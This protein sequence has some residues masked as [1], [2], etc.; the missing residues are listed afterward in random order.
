ADA[1]GSRFRLP[2]SRLAQRVAHREAPPVPSEWRGR[3]RARLAIC[4]GFF[5]LWTAGIEAR[6]VYLQVV[7]HA[8]MMARANR[9]QLRT[10]KLP[11]KR[12][13]IVDRAGHVLAYSVDADTIAADP[14]EID[15]PGAVATRV[16]AALEHCNAQQ[17]DVMAERLSGKGQ[18]T[19]LA[20]QVSPDD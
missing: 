17:R 20:R 6:L 16:C 18:F 3:L 1:H 7:E 12:G 10:V 8:D 9:Q 14:S 11:A 19:Y 15:D 4:A 5:A 13:E 2:W